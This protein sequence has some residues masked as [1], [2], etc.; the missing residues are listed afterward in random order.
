MDTFDMLHDLQTQ[1]MN[2]IPPDAGMEVY[3]RQLVKTENGHK[4]MQLGQVIDKELKAIRE[5]GLWLLIMEKK[6]SIC[7]SM[8][9]LLPIVWHGMISTMSKH[10]T[11]NGN[12]EILRKLLD[13]VEMKLSTEKRVE[14]INRYINSGDGGVYPN[15]DADD[16]NSLVVFVDKIRYLVELLR[17]FIN[18]LEH[19]DK[20]KTVYEVMLSIKMVHAASSFLNLLLFVFAATNSVYK[21]Q[22][23]S[24]DD[25]DVFATMIAAG[26][27]RVINVVPMTKG[28]INKLYAEVRK[29]FELLYVRFSTANTDSHRTMDMSIIF[30]HSLNKYRD[31]H[32]WRLI[33]DEIVMEQ[34]QCSTSTQLNNVMSNAD[35]EIVSRG[36]ELTTVVQ[37]AIECHILV[38]VNLLVRML[39][40]IVRV[41]AADVNEIQR[42]LETLEMHKN[43][44]NYVSWS[45]EKLISSFYMFHGG[46]KSYGIAKDIFDGTNGDVNELYRVTDTAEMKTVIRVYLTYGVRLIGLA[47]DNFVS[48]NF[49]DFISKDERT[50]VRRVLDDIWNILTS[51]GTPL[52]DNVVKML[53]EW[54]DRGQQVYGQSCYSGSQHL[55]EYLNTFTDN[56]NRAT[57]FDEYTITLGWLMDRMEGLYNDLLRDLDLAEMFY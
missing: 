5:Y 2:L 55:P 16:L 19:F 17:P 32:V 15:A 28:E 38:Y 33:G 20:F 41:F 30:Y 37:N 47:V 9:Y 8:R 52:G 26:G 22:C 18:N 4:Y 36:A 12:P 50:D 54:Y 31:P 14:E 23:C 3:C 48:C 57:L 13:K 7:R 6:A 43:L 25:R 29:D 39:H 45:M 40:S 51:S 27:Q 49:T 21:S 56:M 42:W 34:S 35:R 46:M 53:T 24:T 11:G 10:D 44:G 1:C